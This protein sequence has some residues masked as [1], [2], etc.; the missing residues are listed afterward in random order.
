MEQK[1]TIGM[2]HHND[3]DGAYFSIQDIRKELLFNNRADLLRNIEFVIIEN[4]QKSQHAEAVQNL[5]K[6]G[7]M[8]P[9]RVINMDSVQGTSATRNKI[10]EEATG[11]FV[12]VMDCH[13]LLCPTV[14]VIE[15]LFTFMASH[16]TSDDLYCGPLVYD[17]M[18]NLSTHYN[19]TWGGQM[20]GQW[21]QAWQCV[22]EAYNF[23]VTNNDGQCGYVSLSH[24][25]KISAC[26]YCD[27]PF[28]ATGHSGHEGNL[29]KQGY[30]T[31]GLGSYE[32]PFEVF[33]QGLGLFLTR[34]NAWL[35]FNEHAKG[36]GGEECVIHEKYR[37]AGRKTMC[38]PFLKWVHRF[39]RPAGVKYPLTIEN[40]VRNYIL[41]FTEVGLDMA[42]L[43]QHFVDEHNFPESQWNDLINEANIIYNTSTSTTQPEEIMEQI[44]ALQSQL[45]ELKKKGNKCCKA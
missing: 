6:N 11:N 14:K 15:Q 17:S 29:R 13:V 23:S 30:S 26:E 37:Q 34:K 41:G 1:L 42:P 8:T 12:M 43:R 33:A 38:L 39:D 24:Q 3:F 5:S 19:D 32:A 16:N 9:I 18:S 28:P 10:I 7:G 27:N 40:K 45:S 22:C 2:A 21:G 4:D 44:Q 36:F 31:I 20:W 25:K 35:G